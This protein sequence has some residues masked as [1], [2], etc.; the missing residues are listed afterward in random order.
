MLSAPYCC[1]LRRP[2]WFLRDTSGAAVA[3]HLRVLANFLGPTTSAIPLGVSPGRP[4]TRDSAVSAEGGCRTRPRSSLCSYPSPE[5]LRPPP[6]AAPDHEDRRADADC[7]RKACD[8]IV[9]A[10]P[11]KTMARR[12]SAQPYSGPYPAPR[13]RH[14]GWLLLLDL[15]P[16]RLLARREGGQTRSVALMLYR[17]MTGS[18]V[19]PTS[20]PTP[21]SP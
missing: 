16:R 15:D 11:G 4:T 19:S 9:R 7:A 10:P 13:T 17:C 21:S 2:P 5:R 3:F 1:Q 12:A 20:P 18:L 14:G 6:A 8:L